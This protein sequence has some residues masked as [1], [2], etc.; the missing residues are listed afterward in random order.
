MEFFA[1]SEMKVVQKTLAMKLSL[2]H[3]EMMAM[4]LLTLYLLPFK[5][6]FN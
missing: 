1:T 5:I 3:F 6:D 4:K 2:T